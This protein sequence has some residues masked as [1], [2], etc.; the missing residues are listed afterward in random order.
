MFRYYMPTRIYFGKNN[1][2]RLAEVVSRSAP[3]HISIFMGHKSARASGALK[4]I[5][6]I[7]SNYDVSVFEGIEPNPAVKS[8]KA[9][10]AHCRRK[11][12]DLIIAIG[13]GSVIDYAKA[14]SVLAKEKDGFSGFFYNKNQQLKSGKIRFIAVSTTF[15]TS[16]EITPYSVM[17]DPQDQIKI[18]LTDDSL[19]PDYAFINPEFTLSMAKPLVAASCADLLSHAIEAYWS[20]NST[21][22]TDNFA[23]SAIRLFLRNYKQTFK[24]PKNLRI[25]EQVSLASIYAGLAFSNTKTTACHSISYPMTT[26]FNI[27]HGIA[28]AL[29]LAEILKFNSKAR[30]SKVMNLCKLLECRSVEEAADKITSILN[31]LNIKTRLRDYGIAK[32]ELM[33]IV[34]KGFTP[35][36]MINNPR[37]ITREDLKEILKEIH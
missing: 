25:R 12:T 13:G 15:G 26:V 2:P 14:V 4:Q 36:R 30:K 3:K 22:L 37:K 21:E 1:L 19:Y 6:S 17:T 8:L 28:S 29:T 11:N 16:S 33:V 7:L 27:P 9:G 10:I 5:S 35:K 31:N 34:D 20:V 18:T 24:S 23:I 32:N